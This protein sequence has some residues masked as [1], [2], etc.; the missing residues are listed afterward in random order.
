[1][2]E[3][4][5]YYE[6]GSKEDIVISNTS[7]SYINPEQGGS[8]KKFINF[9]SEFKELQESISLERGSLLHDWHEHQENF[10]IAD[11][12]KPSIMMAGWVERVFKSL[13]LANLSPNDL[14]IE[15]IFN[16]R[17]GAYSNIKD[18]TKLWNKFN[19]E[20]MSYLRF[21]F[22]VEGKV[23]MTTETKNIV[24]KSM[25][26]LKEHKKA[27]NILFSEPS[28]GN[29][30]IKEL[31]VYWEIKI[32]EYEKPVKFKAKLDNTI[33]DYKHKIVY[34]NDLKS[35][36]KPV[37]TFKR[38][39]FVYYRYYRQLAFYTTAVFQYLIQIGEDP[40]EW[41]VIPRIIAVD[42]VLYNVHSFTIAPEWLTLGHKEMTELVN[43]VIWHFVSNEWKY[44]AEEVENKY[45]T[46][47]DFT[48][49]DKIFTE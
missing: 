42:S 34:L 19:D 17:E 22:S 3:K 9:F 12:E 32:P 13:Q 39:S 18:T 10:V 38:G 46:H 21:L 48:E 29:K 24:T 16:Y 36:S 20:G 8:P 43:R 6:V 23:A 35:T 45:D 14:S 27:N 7:L 25:D 4:L 31:E 33:I 40:K 47:L 5:N 37:S 1:M 11:V 30:R 49:R 28:E 41:S 15:I 2:S 44:T 26:A